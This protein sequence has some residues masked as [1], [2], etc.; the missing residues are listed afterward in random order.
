MTDYPT[1]LRSKINDRAPDVEIEFNHSLIH[2][3]TKPHQHDIILWALRQQ[4]ALIAASFGL[5]KTQIET[6]IARL[7]V[8]ANQDTKFLLLC[9]LG[10]RHQFIDVDGPRLGIPWQYVYDD[11]TLAAADTSFVLT[12]YERV[13]DSNITPSKHNIIGVSLDEGSVM[14]SL[15]SKTVNVFLDAFRN[16][17]YRYIATATPCP[18]SYREIIYYADFLGVMD[19][20]QALTR[21]FKRNPNKAG[22]LQI[23]PQHEDEFWIWVSTWALFLYHPSDMGYDEP[24]Y[25]LPKL[26]VHWHRI[27]VDHSRA[28]NYYDDRGQHKL[29]IDSTRNV[30]QMAKEKRITL[31]ARVEKMREIM[32]IDI[33]DG[34]WHY[35]KEN[36]LLWHNLEDERRAIEKACPGAAAVYGSLDLEKREEI[37]L[38]FSNGK[39]K[40]LATKPELSGSGCNFQHHCHSN[41]FLG[42]DYKF[43]DFIQAIHRT[44]RYQQKHDVDVHIIYA[45]SEEPIAAALKD[46]WQRHDELVL[47][48]R[49]I[50]RKYGL[51]HRIKNDDLKR[52][53]GVQTNVVEGEH[54]RA[55]NN[56]CVLETKNIAGD[57]IGLIHTSIPFGN[58][59]EYTVQYEDFGHNVG[60]DEFFAQM[61]FL[62]PELYRVLKPGRI[63]A[64]HV[65][66][67]ILYGHQT[68]SGCMEVDPFSDL[69]VTAF[70][71]HGF[72]YEGRRT[73]VTDVVRE[74]NST[75]RL[76]WTEMTKDA[77]KMGS[78]LPEYLLLFRKPPTLKDTARADE[79]VARDKAQYSRGRWQID[80]HAFWRSNGNVI[81]PYDYVEH[82]K[83]LEELDEKGHLPAS[84]FC[85]PPA[86]I[87]EHVWDD[88]TFMRC[89]NS[90]QTQ[91]KRQNHVCP[92]PLD[93]VERVINLYS[94]PADIVLDPFA[95]LFTV[96][97]CAIK[98]GRIGWGIELNDQYFADG[99][100]YCKDIEASSSAP[101]LFDLKESA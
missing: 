32:E 70:R 69:T 37:I 83:H 49:A 62:I 4:C 56:D 42:I 68:K 29:L 72:L 41:I 10:V 100:R 54:F 23:H 47:K 46:K 28:G 93:I 95:G 78:G 11:A 3:S 87:S 96:P 66:D 98:L 1:F 34:H 58:H 8:A 92:L 33:D 65:K 81:V 24:G 50:I 35:P 80:A 36:W 90:S 13:R 39:V 94:N 55:V 16:V 14:R 59:Y 82:F 5:G 27:P 64:I 45:E 89:L 43:E 18:N 17:P 38:N 15:G 73:I 60:N 19:H 25:D 52:R 20:G 67:R 2:P 101:T 91:R 21:W 6:E 88:I 77:S 48:M 85:D 61:D 9:P 57:S 30:S 44:L 99:V 86:S 40:M 97:Y 84:F 76:G 63:A 31:P 26:N 7:L 12:N 22:D 74:N 51:D 71:K 75:Y 53:I 79:P